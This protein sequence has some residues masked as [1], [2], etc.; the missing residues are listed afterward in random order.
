MVTRRKGS[1]VAV[2][3]YY[4]HPV[5]SYGTK[6][7]S[8]DLQLIASLGL[9]VY[10]PN[11]PEDDAGYRKDGMSHFAMI[12]KK[13]DGVVFRAFPDGKIPAGVAFEIS[14]ARESGKPVI[15]LP[16]AIIERGLNPEETRE[17]LEAVR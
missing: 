2:I 16:T 13:C 3:F 9:S 15:E 12:V 8:R 7:E 4:A 11:N 6:Q 1:G 17:R 5:S 14:L 10:N